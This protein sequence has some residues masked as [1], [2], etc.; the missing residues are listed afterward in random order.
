[1]KCL[2]M[3]MWLA[4]EDFC[5][6]ESNLTLTGNISY[7]VRSFKVTEGNGFRN[8]L[9]QLSQRAITDRQ[10]VAL[11]FSFL[12]CFRLPPPKKKRKK[13]PV[14]KNGGSS[15]PATADVPAFMP[16]QADRNLHGRN[17]RI[18]RDETGVLQIVLCF[19]TNSTLHARH[20]LA[21]V[22]LSVKSFSRY[23]FPH[24]Y[25]SIYVDRSFFWREPPLMS[26]ITFYSSV[27]HFVSGWIYRF[28]V[29]AVITTNRSRQFESD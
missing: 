12:T 29:P 24:T 26:G 23:N 11:S 17:S 5:R 16:V 15:V 2:H 28:G 3:R 14:S 8:P 25:L 4:M 19:F 18:T 21:R 10:V 9:S 22:G 7:L 27:Q 1:M 13:T 20:V 6:N